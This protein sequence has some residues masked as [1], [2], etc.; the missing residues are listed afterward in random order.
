MGTLRVA[1]GVTLGSISLVACGSGSDDAASV[2]EAGADTLDAGAW[3]SKMCGVVE[4]QLDIFNEIIDSDQ[5][6]GGSLINPTPPE[7]DPFG[8]LPLG[9]DAMIA[10]QVVFTT[11]SKEIAA[12]PAPAVPNGAAL[13]AEYPAALNAASD[14]VRSAYMTALRTTVMQDTPSTFLSLLRGSS[15]VSVS[16]QAVSAWQSLGDQILASSCPDLIWMVN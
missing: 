7:D 15:F 9:V 11:L 16:S 10:A 6:S 14:N 2:R 3:V 1:L 13:T 8:D 5:N 4:P 12:L